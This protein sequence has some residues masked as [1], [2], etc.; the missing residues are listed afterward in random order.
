MVSRERGGFEQVSGLA[1]DNE[2]FTASQAE[3]VNVDI[4][5]EDQ[6]NHL[7]S[8]D[9]FKGKT[10]SEIRFASTSIDHVDEKSF[11]NPRSGLEGFHR[12]NRKHWGVKRNTKFVSCD[13]LVSDKNA[14]ELEVSLNTNLGDEIPPPPAMK[15]S[16]S[17]HSILGKKIH[18]RQLTPRKAK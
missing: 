4:R 12:I 11:S 15:P 18:R 8:A 9:P 14:L 7:W 17:S 5:S 10:Q 1:T 16:E 13:A 3:I 2:I 6:D